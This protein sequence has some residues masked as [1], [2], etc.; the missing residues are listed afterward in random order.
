[1]TKTDD[2]TGD[3]FDLTRSQV[4]DR[5]L[6]GVFFVTASGF[7]N[8][9]VGFVGNLLVARMLTPNAEFW[10]VIPSSVHP[11]DARTALSPT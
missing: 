10:T 1:M 9:V 2:T 3:A 8:L 5:A 11:V 4:R 6:A 7:A